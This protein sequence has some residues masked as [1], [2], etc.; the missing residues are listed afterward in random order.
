MVVRAGMNIEPAAAITG[1]TVTLDD[2]TNGLQNNAS[3]GWDN[4]GTGDPAANPLAGAFFNDGGDGDVR[5]RTENYFVN[6]LGRVLSP[7]G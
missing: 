2:V 7:T 4:G 3:R 6:D 1:D 5:A